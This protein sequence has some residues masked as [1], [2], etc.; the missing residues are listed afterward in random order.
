MRRGWVARLEN[1]T[2]GWISGVRIA[3]VTSQFP[4]GDDTTRGRPIVQTLDSLATLAHIQVFVPVARYPGWLVPRSYKY[5]TTTAAMSIRDGY[6][7]KFVDYPTVP[8]VG[9]ALNGLLAAR[10][11]KGPICRFQPDLILAYWLYPDAYGASV[12]AKELGVPLVSGA[13]GSDIRARDR[14]SLMLT[15]RVLERSAAMLT[16]SEDLGRIVRTEFGVD[17][18]VVFTVPNGCNVNVFH[19]GSRQAARQ[20]LKVPDDGPLILYVGRLV[21][22]KGLRE[23]LA[24]FTAL[25]ADCA[26]AR[27]ALVG[28]GPLAPELFSA[29]TK[30]GIRERIIL[31][32]AATPEQVATWMLACNVFCLPSH[33]EGYP[34]VLVEALACGRP[35]VATPVGGI[36]EIVDAETGLFTPVGDANSLSAALRES[37]DRN[38][39]ESVLS[40]RFRRSWADVAAETLAVCDSVYRGRRFSGPASTPSRSTNRTTN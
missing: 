14:I 17:P 37:L 28:E 3:V 23:L 38:W 35:V 36:V 1:E 22:A 18:D 5:V 32:G 19:P 11:L 30:A 6:S 9:R 7:A 4:T 39:D 8:V 16:V 20:R 2:H 24:A 25:Q 34:N 12:V 13:R 15:R 40:R 33:T 26:N 10:S 29:A 31:P 21:A 27:L